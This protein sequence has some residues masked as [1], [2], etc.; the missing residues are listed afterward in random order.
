ML[1]YINFDVI[2]FEIMMT[3]DTVPFFS[4]CDK[5]TIS[6]LFIGTMHKG[7]KKRHVRGRSAVSAAFTLNK[8]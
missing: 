7:K 6:S 8:H 3:R 4:H 1:H 2:S 5:F